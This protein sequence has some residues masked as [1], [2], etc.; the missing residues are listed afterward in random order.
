MRFKS[1]AIALG[2][3][4][5]ERT[6][7]LKEVDSGFGPSVRSIGLKPTVGLASQGC[8]TAAPGCGSDAPLTSGTPVMLNSF[9]HLVSSRARP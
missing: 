3:R 6:R 9:Q 8:G 1:K 5:G 7:P 4:T 2:A